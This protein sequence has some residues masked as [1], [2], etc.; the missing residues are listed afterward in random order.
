MG[1]LFGGTQKTTSSET[2]ESG[3]SKFQAPYLTTAFDAARDNFTASKGSSY[4][5][6][7]TYAG[8]SDDQK[9]T[10]DRIRRFAS[11]QGMSTSDTIS[12][13]GSGL[14]DGAS[15][16]AIQNLD[17]FTDLAG[18]D[19]TSANI[20][21]AGRYADSPYL[22]GQI[23]AVSRDVNRNLT[24]STLPGIDR[25]ASGTGNINSSRAGV[26]AGIATRGAQDRVADISAQMRGAAYDTGLSRASADRN[27]T[28]DAYRAAAGSFADLTGQG[29]AALGAGT[30]AG[31]DSLDRNA[32]TGAVEQADR[33]GGLDADFNQW[34]G[35][36]QRQQDLL[37][38]YMSIIGA[39]QWGQSATSKGT[40]TSKSGGNIFGQL[41][42]AAATAAAFS[43]RRLK[44]DIAKVGEYEDGLGIYLWRYIW[45]GSLHE[46]VMADEVAQLRPWALGP[47]I[48]GFATVNYDQL[49]RKPDSV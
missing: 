25:A 22:N 48:F 24:E 6:G 44:R 30:Q 12:S 45:G 9:A 10:L 46:G 5:Q 32:A 28:L 18:T 17:R 19:A 13:V 1:S 23:D 35:Q 16:K 29:V 7:D 47:R 21:A 39:N 41:A 15:G 49:H 36:D 14:I 33:Q 40:G 11:G 20:A 4:Y 31:Y 34:Q 37:E 2:S 8:L 43:D 26:A 38:R 42:G 3:P 27:A